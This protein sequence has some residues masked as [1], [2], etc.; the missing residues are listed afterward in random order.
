M[1]ETMT[2]LAKTNPK[3]AVFMLGMLV[4]M[5]GVEGLPFAEDLEDLID[6]LAQ[7]LFN[8]PFNSKRWLRNTLKSASEAV[9][10]ADLSGVLMHGVANSLTGLNFASRVG[11]GNLIPGTRIGAADVDYRRAMDEILGPV[12]GMVS[13]MVEGADALS[14]GDFLEAAKKGLPLAAKNAVKGWEQFEKGYATDAGGRKLVDVGSWEAF[15]QSVGFSSSTLSQVY[16]SDTIDRRTVA[17][18]NDVRTQ[19]TKEMVSAIRDGDRAAANEVGQ[20]IMAWN[21]AHPDMPVA[22][23]PASLRRQVA[24]AGMPLNQRTLLTMPKYL[25]GQSEAAIGLAAE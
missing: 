12:G 5:A 7:R 13:G 24:L 14:K 20:A 9:V 11:A 22:M 10:G 25:R 6:V 1:M 19:F 18:Y 21:Q 16:E 23:S 8:E 3:S 17:F 15:W 4:L 2:F